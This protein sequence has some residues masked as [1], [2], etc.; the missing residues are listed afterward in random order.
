MHSFTHTAYTHNNNKKAQCARARVC[1]FVCV[2]VC[3]CVYNYIH[4]FKI[5]IFLSDWVDKWIDC[6]DEFVPACMYA[7]AW[8]Y[9]NVFVDVQ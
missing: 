2:C 4:V 6:F 5:F 7:Q 3:M 8:Q 1:V 9:V